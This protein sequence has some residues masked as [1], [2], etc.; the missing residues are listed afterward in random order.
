MVVVANLAVVGGAPVG[1]GGQG[2]CTHERGELLFVEIEVWPASKATAQVQPVGLDLVVV[3]VGVLQRHA[4]SWSARGMPG[5]SGGGGQVQG[6]CT[7]RMA[8]ATLT[9]LSPPA[10]KTGTRAASTTSFEIAQSWTRP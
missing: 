8:S 6:R 4:R 1:S 3:V 5:G 9:S 2:D 10:R 7:W